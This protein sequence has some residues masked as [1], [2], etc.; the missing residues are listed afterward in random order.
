MSSYDGNYAELIL[1]C[2][3]F[4]KEDFERYHCFYKYEENIIK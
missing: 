2:E 1:A 3:D 4:S